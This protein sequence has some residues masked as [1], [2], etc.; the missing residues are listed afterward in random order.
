M[1]PNPNPD[2]ISAP[3]WDV[4]WASESLEY[5]VPAAEIEGEEKKKDAAEEDDTQVPSGPP[6][7]KFSSPKPFLGLAA[8]VIKNYDTDWFK[9][10]SRT[11]LMTTPL[12]EGFDD[13]TLFQ[14]LLLVK[15]LREDKLQSS[16]NTFVAKGLGPKFGESPVA[17]ISDI[18]KDLDNA[19]PCIFILSKGAD[20]TGMLLRFARNMD[21]ELHIVSLGQGQ[22]PIAKK[23]V[24]DGCKSGDWVV[25]QNCMLAKS[26]LPTLDTIIFQLQEKAKTAGGGGIHPEFRLYLTSS[27]CDYFPVS[28][29]QN[30]VKMTNEPPKGFRS[31]T[32]RSFSNLIKEEKWES[33]VKKNEFKKL[34]IGLA[35]FHANLQE[36]R[37]FGPLGW[38]IMYAFDESDLETSIA[39]LH[40]FL[41]EQE[42]IPWDALNFVTG[43]INYGG[44]VTDDWDRRCLMSML[45]IYF[46]PEVL[47]EGYK[48]SKSGKYYAP[49]VG[50]LKDTIS[51]FESLPQADEPEVFGM[52]DNANVTYNTN[53]SL[54]L[55]ATLLSL[56]P[57]SSGGS[58]G[59]TSD[60]IVIDQASDFDAECPVIL[61]ADDAGPT[62]F[63]IQPNGLLPSLAICLEQEMIKFNRLINR[64][65]TSLKDI[66]LAIRGMIVMSAD[67]DMMYTSFMN[68]QLPPIWEKVSFASLKTLGSWFTDLKYRVVFMRKWVTDGQPAAFPLPVFFFPQGF[69][70]GCLQTFA[71][72]YMA[73]IDGLSFEFQIMNE[74]PEQITEGPEDGVYI[75][76]LFLEGAR[77]DRI[78]GYVTDSEP[79]TMYD[80]LPLIH[81]KPAVGHKQPPGTYAC[82]VYKTAVRK[83]VLSTTGLSTNFVVAV[84][85]PSEDPEQKWI[86]SGC[87]ALCNLTD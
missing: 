9:W 76:G 14:R 85:L 24:E 58:G 32:L 26:W 3:Q 17:S 61:N 6:V 43:H 34:L 37:K 67:L 71:R 23:L 56:Q 75:F 78:T 12:P 73:A 60:E 15:A 25:L 81:F 52:H 46:V 4:V 1:P 69:M 21:K 87:A 51:F 53:E 62:T 74:A 54:T 38:N 47:G 20:P 30:G 65:K 80:S 28:I 50:D 72:K 27:P 64:I 82:P 2:K 41:E 16:I 49:P 86:L 13:A 57:R 77:F 55:M 44:R 63:V 11:D 8:H 31:N 33:C 18:Y 79:G 42:H 68:N 83:G 36:R 84:E 35:F 40:R 29:L 7:H 45:S 59:K 39:V 10:S 66:R 48:F 5:T 22:G 19:T 70:T